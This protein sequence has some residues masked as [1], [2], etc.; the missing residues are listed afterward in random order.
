VRFEPR[1]SQVV[2]V[3]TTM[4]QPLQGHIN[5]VPKTLE[6]KPKY[7]LDSDRHPTCR[8]RYRDVA[9]SLVAMFHILHRM[10]SSIRG[11]NDVRDAPLYRC[12]ESTTIFPCRS[13]PETYRPSNTSTLYQLIL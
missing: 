4:R 1:V 3:V 11:T 5:S 8:I 13:I 7:E 10:F 12:Q 9:S 2:L 6:K